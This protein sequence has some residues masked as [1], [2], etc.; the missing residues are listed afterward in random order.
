M[1]VEEALWVAQDRQR[2]FLHRTEDEVLYGGAAG[3]GKTDALLADAIRLCVEHPGAKTM[4]LRR[5]F[6]DL[7]R[8]GSA[9]DR[10]KELLTGVANWRGSDF[11]WEF[12]DYGGSVLA[13][14]HLE[15][16]GDVYSYQGTQLDGL[17]WDEVTQFTEEQYQF[18]RSRVRATVPGVKPKIRAA[19]NPGN[20]G[21]GWVRKRWVDAAPWGSPF[22]IRAESGAVIASGC[23]IPARVS[24]NR[25]L[26]ERDP[27]YATRLEGLPEHLRRAYLDGDWDIFAGQVF[28]EWRR[29][30]HVVRAFTVPKDWPRWCGVD[31]GYGAPWC[32]LWLARAPGGTVYVYREAYQK[33]LSDWDQA[34]RIRRESHGED[35]RWVVADPSAFSKQPNGKSIADVYFDSAGIRLSRG[36]NDRLSGLQ[37]LHEYLRP[38]VEGLE[39]GLQVFDTCANLIRTLPALVYDD[40]NVED[41]DS[42]SDDHSYDALRYALMASKVKPPAAPILRD[43]VA[44][45]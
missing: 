17:Y 10:S 45:M 22:P 5:T 9:I 2:E 6:K 39:P 42:A 13:F 29:D 27:G 31:F 34:K 12:A 19:T 21:H 14:A 33:G 16:P 4:F 35:V 37:R 41:V 28:T 15:N 32:C 44:T 11:K 36:N 1:V 24:D 8:P 43:F 18:L 25:R 26:L 23:F 3:G 40:H 20:I 7:S 30:K 38:G